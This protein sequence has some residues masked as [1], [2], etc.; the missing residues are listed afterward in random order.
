M[1]CISTQQTQNNT[2]RGTD[3]PQVIIL[4]RV[5][6]GQ[7]DCQ[8]CRGREWPSQII[9]GNMVCVRGVQVP[10]IHA[11]ISCDAYTQGII[12]KKPKTSKIVGHC[13]S[14]QKAKREETA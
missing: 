9:Q 2:S 5:W 7:I 14:G 8:G 13:K 3:G 1:G 11:Y 12:R 6:G 10:P 4:T